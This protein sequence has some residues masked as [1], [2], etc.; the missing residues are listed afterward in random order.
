MIRFR[1]VRGDKC[2]QKDPVTC[3]GGGNKTGRN[4]WRLKCPVEANGC[5]PGDAVSTSDRRHQRGRD[6]RRQV[7]VKFTGSFSC[8]FPPPHQAEGGFH[9]IG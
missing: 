8:G 6:A 1:V 2:P 3:H 4:R 9:P 7:N 5:G